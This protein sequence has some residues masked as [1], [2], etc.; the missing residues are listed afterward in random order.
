VLNVLR[1][2]RGQ[3]MSFTLAQVN[4]G[5]QIT[6][7]LDSMVHSRKLNASPGEVSLK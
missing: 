2:L 7:W 4:G 1:M 5:G 6:C 3:G